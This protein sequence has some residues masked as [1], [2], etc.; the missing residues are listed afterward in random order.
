MKYSEEFKREALRVSLTSGLP[1][2]RV[3]S[4][5]GVGSRHWASGYQIIDHLI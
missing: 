5:L 4:D 3:A 2:E 1:R